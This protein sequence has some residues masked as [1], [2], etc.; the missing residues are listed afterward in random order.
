MTQLQAQMENESNWVLSTNSNFNTTVQ[1]SM[2]IL[3]QILRLKNIV[4]GE[5]MKFSPLESAI[6]TQPKQRDTLRIIPVVTSYMNNIFNRR[7]SILSC[8]LLKRFAIE[9]QMS[10]LACLDMEPDQIR[11]IFL[12]RLSDDLES[13]DFKIAV[14]EFVEACIE[15]QPGL[16][17]VFFKISYDETKRSLSKYTKT[18]KNVC[19]GIVTYMEEFLDAISTVR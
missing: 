12:Q 1:L 11:L 17:E 2:T 8:R 15:T 5:S 7:L 18:N 13:D 19:E 4:L 6:Y 3:M 16:T 10:L 9:F 14:L